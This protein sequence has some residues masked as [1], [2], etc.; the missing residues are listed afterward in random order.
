MLTPADRDE[1]IR[2]M[3]KGK[4]EMAK[5][6]PTMPKTADCQGTGDIKNI[7]EAFHANEVFVAKESQDV[8][9][10]FTKQEREKIADVVVAGLH[11][12]FNR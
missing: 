12:L 10:E 4:P 7:I 9:E 5:T 1:A 3:T 2:E 11:K 8:D 6:P